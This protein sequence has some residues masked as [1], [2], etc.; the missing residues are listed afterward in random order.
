MRQ[1]TLVIQVETDEQADEAFAD[2]LDQARQWQ[3]DDEEL[4]RDPYLDMFVAD[5]LG[6]VSRP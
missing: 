2:L 5:D 1:V 6:T 4:D 3:M